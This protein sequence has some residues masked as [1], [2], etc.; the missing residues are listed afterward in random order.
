MVRL[1]ASALLDPL[2]GP[3]APRRPRSGTLF[4]HKVF[5]IVVLQKSI[6]VQIRQL[7]L[8]ISNITGCVDEFVRKLTFATQFKKHAGGNKPPRLTARAAPSSFRHF[9][10]PTLTHG[11]IASFS[12]WVYGR[13]RLSDKNDLGLKVI[14]GAK[15]SF[16][17]VDLWSI[18]SG[19]ARRLYLII[20]ADRACRAVLV[21]ALPT[22][23][24]R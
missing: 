10:P 7:I 12:V 8:Y 21:H 23:V 6:P 13:I 3:R 19:C 20:S 16:R 18:W 14:L 4:S 1:C 11:P 15:E 22:G 9:P 17:P 5:L 24:P 2:G